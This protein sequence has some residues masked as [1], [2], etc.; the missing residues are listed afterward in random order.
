MNFITTIVAVGLAATL[1]T[2]CETS[3]S[4]T[5]SEQAACDDP[6]PDLNVVS[7]APDVPEEYAMFSG[8][9]KG[10]WERRLCASFVIKTVGKDGNVEGVYSWGRGRDFDP[11]YSEFTSMI[12]DG[13]V[14]F[15]GRANFTFWLSEARKGEL[16]GERRARGQLS[17]VTMLRAKAP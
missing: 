2:A 13:K 5:A 15:R 7:P 6:L 4:T 12:E 9:W 11:G 14:K 3:Q 8:V 17:R 1:L 16:R 10:K